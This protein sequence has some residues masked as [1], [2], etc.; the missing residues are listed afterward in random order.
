MYRNRIIGWSATV[1]RVC[2]TLIADDG[3]FAGLVDVAQL[4]VADRW[5]DLAIAT[6]SISWDI[7]FGRSYDELFFEVYGMEPDAERISLYRRLWDESD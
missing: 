3:R 4:G 1:I 2:P 5:A 6:Y 7:N